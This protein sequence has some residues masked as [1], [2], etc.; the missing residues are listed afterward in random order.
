MDYKNMTT[1]ELID[2]QKNL[3]DEINNLYKCLELMPKGTF[4]GVLSLKSTIKKKTK[5][6]NNIILELK[7]RND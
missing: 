2:V 1:V 6:L 7:S 4:L 3:E 5:K